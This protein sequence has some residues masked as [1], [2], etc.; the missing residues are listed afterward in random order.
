MLLTTLNNKPRHK[1]QFDALG[2]RWVIET[3]KS[4]DVQKSA[5]TDR[6]EIFDRTYSRFRDDSLV[7]QLAEKPGTYVFPDDAKKLIEYYD[8]LYKQTDGAV[9]PLVGNILDD[10]GYDKHYSL[11]P[12]RVTVAPVWHDVMQWQDTTLRT[13]RAVLLDF[14]A[15]GK[16]YL[17]DLIGEILEQYDHTN[18]VIDA[19]GDSRS[20]GWVQT[21]GLENP[22]DPTM[23]IGTVE[24][25]N[26]SLCASAVNRRAWGN[27][28]HIVDPRNA[29]P[30]RDVVATWVI[31][32]TTL[33]ADGLATALFFALD[34]SMLDESIAFVR[35]FADGAV[36]RSP[37]FV[38]ELFI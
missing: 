20:R 22:F 14:G 1:W 38:G 24:V 29:Q 32:P 4:I 33:Q 30:V 15:A 31:A 17:V 5:I 27:W 23:V 6:I 3:E 21:I 36:E 11:Q 28:H 26:A 37:A 13:T 12:G 16:G 18:Y 2:T 10:A 19:S 25:E 8:Y 34:T 9:S 35:L 7:A